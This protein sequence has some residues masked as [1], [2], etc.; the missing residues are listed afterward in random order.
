MEESGIVTEHEVG[1]HVP[2]VYG[3]PIFLLTPWPN[4]TAGCIPNSYPLLSV[5]NLVAIFLVLSLEILFVTIFIY[6]F[7]YCYRF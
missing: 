5:L 3:F 1:S 4:A 2:I 7:T 6:G